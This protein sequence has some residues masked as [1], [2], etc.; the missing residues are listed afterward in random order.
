MDE[1]K[2]DALSRMTAE[3]MARPFPPG[4]RGLS[5]EGQDMVLLDADAYGSAMSVLDGTLT[6][7]HRANLARLAAVCDKV[8]PAIEDEYAAVYYA[9]VRD[10]AVLAVEIEDLRGRR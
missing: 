3:H 1:E 8:L 7:R 6:D 2:R 4:F 9:H 5:V 10:M